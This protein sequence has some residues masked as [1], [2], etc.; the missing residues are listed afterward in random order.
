MS[1]GRSA[2]L[3]DHP[4]LT[5]VSVNGRG[6]SF[7]MEGAVTDLGRDVACQIVLGSKT[8]SRRHARVLRSGEALILEDLGSTSGTVLNGRL[9]DGRVPL[10]HG[11]VIGVG[12]CS[13]RVFWK[14][15][16]TPS[17]S[18]EET[19]LHRRDSSATG[20][21]A[22]VGVRSEEKLLAILQITRDLMGSLE[23]DE[24]LA[25]ILR[26]LFRIFPQAGRGFILLEEGGEFVVRATLVK[27]EASRPSGPS[28]TALTHAI[29]SGEAILSSDVLADRRFAGSQSVDDAELRTL[30]CVPLRDHHRRAVGAIE[31]DTSDLQARFT[32][33]DLDLLVTLA[34]QVGMAVDNARLRRFEREATRR[35]A[36]SQ[37]FVDAM[38]EAAPVAMA[39]FDPDLRYERVNESMARLNGLA[40]DDHAGRRIDEVGGEL[41][42]KLEPTVRGVA[43]TGLPV[44]GLEVSLGEDGH[45]LCHAYTA[46]RSD[47]GP[48]GI[49][50]MLEDVSQARRAKADLEESEGRYRLLF[51]SNPHPMWVYDLEDLR[52]LAVNEAAVHRYGYS[53]EEFL[54]M[55]IADIRPPEDVRELK[56]RIIKMGESTYL[57]A[58]GWRHVTKTGDMLDVE[59]S[60]HAITFAGRP[61]RLVLASDITQR[62]RAEAALLAAKEAAESANR[63]KDRFLAVLSHE[64]R[65]PL[66]PVLLAATSLAADDATPPALRAT[67]EMILR[68]VAL[69]ARLVDDLLDVAKI[70]H[71]GLRLAVET[72][73]VHELLRE[74]GEICQPEARAAGMRM[75]WALAAPRHHAMVD[76]ARMRQGFWNVIRNAAR[77]SRSGGQLQI[78]TS[79]P[80]AEAAS[81]GGPT[82]P[83]LV[84]D[85]RD[86]GVGIA[87][88]NLDRIF[89]PFERGPRGGASPDGGLGLGLAISR[90]IVQGHGGRLSVESPGPGLGATFRF[91]LATIPAPSAG[92]ELD[93]GKP[94][95]LA[96]GVRVLL[97]E[98]NADSRRYLELALTREGFEVVAARDIETALEAIHAGH[99][100]LLISDIQ[101]PDGSGLELMDELS[102]IRPTPAIAISGYGSEEDLQASVRAGFTVH[103]TKPITIDRLKTAIARALGQTPAG[104]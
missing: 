25:Q 96:H 9:V 59:I 1:V 36:E 99:F 47:G 91:E 72:V 49:G 37:A 46:G 92:K 23:L 48:M 26:S 18:E 63:A 19:I 77:F 69:E 29:A 41:A 34:A 66:T 27:T 55:T 86:D 40:A 103:L 33:D 68:N 15:G 28:R 102:R 53:A 52:F 24:V 98:D 45:W 90:T 87:R 84:I 81:P 93:P 4:R 61:A 51:E 32:A 65:T 100:G 83:M 54:G 82:P 50:V 14:P 31:L 62:V 76:P 88:E 56:L 38:L 75:D 20:E 21:W 58:G 35:Q 44:V 94:E 3:E 67:M 42:A 104:A 89:E 5:V 74:A 7:A 85:F 6:T 2:S 39:F 80:S 17:W 95:L 12:E 73:D 57:N 79:N 78:R 10:K 22:L 11:D 97:V 101:L 70:E 43:R 64:L 71:G 60:S 8:V 16:A 13:L 30:M